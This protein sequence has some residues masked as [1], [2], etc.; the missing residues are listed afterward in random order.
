MHEEKLL[1]DI[2]INAHQV[3]HYVSY[4]RLNHPYCRS[5]I[6]KKFVKLIPSG[7]QNFG[8]ID[9]ISISAKISGITKRTFSR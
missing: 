7:I 3:P 8:T 4:A 1:M 5:I 2:F 6:R 9:G